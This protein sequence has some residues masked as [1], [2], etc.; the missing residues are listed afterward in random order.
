MTME[1]GVVEDLAVEIDE[2]LAERLRVR[3]RSLS[4]R[5]RRAGRMLPKPVRRAAAEL[6]EAQQMAQNPH[7]A[8][9]LDGDAVGRAYE[10][11]RRHLSQVDPLAARSR[12]RYNFASL[13]AAQVLIVAAL[14]IAVM[15]WRGLV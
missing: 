3:G 10:T 7:L 2:M 12:A 11:C 9:K 8:T 15:Q 1:Q 6:I 13:V 14:A 4:A 5:V